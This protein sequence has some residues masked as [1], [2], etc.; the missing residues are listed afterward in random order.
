MRLY[1][2]L[3]ASGMCAQ[4][5]PNAEKLHNGARL[6]YTSSMLSINPCVD[7]VVFDSEPT[8]RIH[9]TLPT[10]S[11]RWIRRAD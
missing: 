4:D 2:H 6:T 8:V 11:V 7:G 3:Y 5:A 10:S 1:V 9:L